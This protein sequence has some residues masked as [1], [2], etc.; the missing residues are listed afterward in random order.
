MRCFF[1]SSIVSSCGVG[2]CSFFGGVVGG[3]V[4]NMS[5]AIELLC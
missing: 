1:L 5:R 3:G 4:Q 2:G